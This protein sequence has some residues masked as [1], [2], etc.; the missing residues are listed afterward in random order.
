MVA[1]GLSLGLDTIGGSPSS[2]A[3]IRRADRSVRTM[4]SPRIARATAKATA[5]S[6]PRMSRRPERLPA[7]GVGLGSSSSVGVSPAISSP[8]SVAAPAGRGRREESAAVR[9]ASGEEDGAVGLPAPR[10]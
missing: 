10:R 2:L 5:T 7:T 8:A 3:L 1:G 4:M 9:D 6:I